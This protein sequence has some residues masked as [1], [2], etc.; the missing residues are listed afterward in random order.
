MHYP[1]QINL[2]TEVLYIIEFAIHL[3]TFISYR[4]KDKE[5]CQILKEKKILLLI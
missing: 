5:I 3:K 4:K 2:M 1:T